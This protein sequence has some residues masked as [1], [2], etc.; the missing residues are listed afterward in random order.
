M[1]QYKPCDIS[2]TMSNGQNWIQLKIIWNY[3]FHS[4]TLRM[5]HCGTFLVIKW[6]MLT[7]H[8]FLQYW[9]A[10]YIMTLQSISHSWF[11][12]RP[13]F[14]MK[15]PST[16]FVK[17][18][19]PLHLECKVSGTPSLK[20][21]GNKY[22]NKITDSGHYSTSL[23][24]LVAVLELKTTRFEDSRDFTCEVWNDAETANCSSNIVVKGQKWL[25][26]WNDAFN[27]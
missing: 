12:E 6:I 17:L 21:N 4:P 18:H 23:V 5:W 2:V 10:G 27:F 9:N 15:L 11:P 26:R 13:Q 8:S 7:I 25:W 24:D 16:Q 20:I 1:S 19:E 14:T 22:D 3:L